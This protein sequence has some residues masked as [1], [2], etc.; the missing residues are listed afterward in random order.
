[1]KNVYLCSISNIVSGTC[2]EDC[3]FCTQSVKYKANIERYEKKDVKKVLEEAQA[4][5][6]LGASGFC[7]VTAG[8]SLTPK[9]LDYISFLAEELKTRFPKLNLIACNGTATKQQLKQLKNSG[10]DSYNHNLETSQNFYSQICTTHTWKERFETCENVK[11]VGLRLCTGG[12]IGMGEIDSDRQDFL[13]SLQ[14]L[15]PESIPINFYHHNEALPL[16]P[17]NLTINQGLEFIY[18]TRKRFPNSIVMVAGGRESFFGQEQYKIFEAGA[19]AIII[20]NYLTTKGNEPH[21]DL[22]MLKKLNISII[23]LH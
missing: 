18:E 13:N 7:L 19:N 20:G 17:N 1:M 22:E 2:L 12:I 8:K 6:N 15:N 11:E 5:V 4:L 16:K 10:I 3:K 23:H 21:R 14:K 9:I